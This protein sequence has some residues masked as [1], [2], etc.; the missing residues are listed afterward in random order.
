ME[1][2]ID[3]FWYHL[4]LYFIATMVF[5]ILFIVLGYILVKLCCARFF[6]GNYNQFCCPSFPTPTMSHCPTCP[7]PCVTRQTPCSSRCPSSRHPSGRTSRC[8]HH[9]YSEDCSKQPI[10]QE[11]CE[12]CRSKYYPKES[13]S[14]HMVDEL[15]Y[16]D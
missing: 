7:S 11:N 12:S 15:K 16:P 5:V 13:A 14:F 3:S 2:V 6:C 9:P 8:L 10:L 1:V 4:L